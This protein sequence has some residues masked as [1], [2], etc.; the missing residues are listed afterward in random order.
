M[1][2]ILGR[3][4][5]RE[6]QRKIES[7]YIYI[8][9]ILILLWYI[10][11]GFTLELN[12]IALDR[13]ATNVSLDKE[14][15]KVSHINKDDK[16]YLENTESIEGSK[17][18]EYVSV[19]YGVGTYVIESKGKLLMTSEVT[20]S[21]LMDMGMPFIVIDCVVYVLTII[22]VISK[23]FR[24]FTALSVSIFTSILSYIILNFYITK[25]FDCKFS[26]F[27]VIFVRFLI[28]SIIYLTIK[29]YY[30]RKRKIKVLD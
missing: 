14:K 8:L 13:N 22:M 5:T 15:V 16:I 2:T 17:I 7:I 18:S 27:I 20:K 25:M 26:L 23:R 12:C 30:I 9:V 3:K 4:V 11:I 19:P 6:T 24:N 10:C 29:V 1:Y 28:V 21:E